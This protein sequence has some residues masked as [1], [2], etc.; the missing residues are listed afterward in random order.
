MIPAYPSRITIAII[1]GGCSGSLIAAQLLRRATGPLVIK[2]IERRSELG[3]GVAYS[4]PV[5]CHLL[6]VPAGEMSAFPDEPHHFLGWLQNQVHSASGEFPSEVRADTFV[7][8]KIYGRYL[9]AVLDEAEANAPDR[10]RLERV[11]D[12]VVGTKPEPDGATISLR[13]N[14]VLRVQ[15]IVLAFGNSPPVLRG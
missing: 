4:T 2:L 10:V 3:R 1:G 13:S 7:P 6:N 5:D 15:R 11:N 9:Q 14:Q 12:E 8:R